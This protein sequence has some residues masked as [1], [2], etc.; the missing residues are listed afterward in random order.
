MLAVAD[1]EQMVRL[2]EG[3]QDC[4]VDSSSFKTLS[5]VCVGLRHFCI[6]S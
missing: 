1:I 3:T 4:P 2:K 5:P 6:Y